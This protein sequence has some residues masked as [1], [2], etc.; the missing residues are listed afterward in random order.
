MQTITEV[1]AIDKGKIRHYAIYGDDYGIATLLP[2][3]YAFKVE[4][5]TGTRLVSYKDVDLVLLGRCD[6]VAEA[7]RVDG[8]RVRNCSKT[9]QGVA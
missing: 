9:L 5:A 3:G 7:D 1:K 6:L 8:D 4:G 2:G